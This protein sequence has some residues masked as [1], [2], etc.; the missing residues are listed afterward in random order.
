MTRTTG[1]PAR[2]CADR[3]TGV[4]SAPESASHR[5]Q[6]RGAREPVQMSAGPAVVNGMTYRHPDLRWLR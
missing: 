5:D 3:H 1:G 2:W 6:E 4:A